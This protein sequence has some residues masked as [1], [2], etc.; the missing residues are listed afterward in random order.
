M[1]WTHAAAEGSQFTFVI[2]KQTYLHKILS[3]SF[4]QSNR[5]RLV[6]LVFSSRIQSC[7]I[8]PMV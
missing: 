4:V 2:E 6:R 3:P 7:R 1:E 8:Y 5:L